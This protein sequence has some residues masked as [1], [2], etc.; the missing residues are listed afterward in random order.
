MTEPEQADRR[1]RGL[2][3]VLRGG[4][5]KDV[6]W[7]IASVIEALEEYDD[8]IVERNAALAR[9]EALEASL[10]AALDFIEKSPCD[11]DI[12]TDQYEAW[13]RLQALDAHALLTEGAK[14]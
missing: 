13:K 11:P 14:P 7:G 8:L 4:G 12:Y 6:R 1:P 3:F 2:S 9:V 10:R 5:K